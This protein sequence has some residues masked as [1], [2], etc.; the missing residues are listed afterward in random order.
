M[1]DI[2]SVAIFHSASRLEWKAR[3]QQRSLES[4]K[5][6]R[7]EFVKELE[8]LKESFVTAQERLNLTPDGDTEM[9]INDIQVR[10]SL[11]L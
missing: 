7:Q 11:E 10:D 2:D 3:E 5:H 9:K 6:D 1:L 8:T 4:E